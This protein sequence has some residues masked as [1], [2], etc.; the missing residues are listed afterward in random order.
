MDFSNRQNR[1]VK[2]TEVSS[3]Y[4][5]S[6]GHKTK[7]DPFYPSYHIAPHHGLLNDPNGLSYFNGEHHIFYQW[8]P[9]GPVHGLK[10]WY[11]LSTKD[12][13]SYTDHGIA[14]YPDQE[15]DE[16][17]CYTGIA[18]ADEEK[19]SLFYTANRLKEDGSSEQTQALAYMDKE[20][21]VEKQRVLVENN[22]GN[23]TEN[24]RDPVLFER[25]GNQYMLVGAEG[26]DGKGKLALYSGGTE[27][28]YQYQG[29]LDIGRS[30]FGYMWECPNYYETEG[31][32]VLIFSPQGV[33]SDNK[34]DLKNVFSV[35]YSVGDLIDIENR[36]FTS[37]SY[38]ELDK[39]FD[40]YAPQIYLD[41]QGRRVLYGWLG[42]SK[43][44]YPTDKNCWAHMLTLPREIKIAGNKLIQNPL[45]EM[46]NLRMDSVQVYESTPLNNAA[47][48]LSLD[49]EEIF[50]L[51]FSNSE[52]D[53]VIFCG[54]TEEYMLDRSASTYIYAERYGQIRYAKRLVANHKIKI[55]VDN[56]SIE[57]FC[58][59]GETVFTSRMFIE[60]LSLLE[61]SGGSGTLYYLRN[62]ELI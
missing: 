42:N 62:I 60:N 24:F 43:S 31:K 45:I 33:S 17:G 61:L 48:E 59:N 36:K 34:Y 21:R 20:G 30:N 15:Y 41:D 2:L 26:N 4:L 37:D 35:V 10:H 19:L 50:S 7:S 58:D 46:E 39:G 38:I 9:L 27:Q 13:V 32:G 55:F 3:E 40:F 29:D 5:A 1:F 52:G 25:N 49:V 54:D 57:I 12:F 6:I 16:H 51:S 11:H 8:F 14:M 53:R 56:S 44:E 28:D 23:Y 18:I 47:F 22:S